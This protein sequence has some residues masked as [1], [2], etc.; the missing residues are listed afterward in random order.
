MPVLAGPH[1]PGFTD[2]HP[3]A[4]GPVPLTV[5]LPEPGAEGPGGPRTPAARIRP[6]GPPPL[7]SQG[8][9]AAEM[10]F[11]KRFPDVM[12]PVSE[13]GSLV[14]QVQIRGPLGPMVTLRQVVGSPL[15]SKEEKDDMEAVRRFQVYD[16]VTRHAGRMHAC[17]CL[18]DVCWQAVVGLC[19]DLVEG[20]QFTIRG[21]SVSL[22][23]S[24]TALTFHIRSACTKH[25]PCTT[26]LCGCG[27]GACRAAPV[28]A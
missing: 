24:C 12:P 11:L 17:Q 22:A 20:E 26:S 25:P 6:A 27:P 13:S 15:P 14:I 10:L 8:L 18:L 1:M 5:G 3:R 28:T 9:S 21:I 4:P 23:A 7:Y 2:G 16:D 19:S